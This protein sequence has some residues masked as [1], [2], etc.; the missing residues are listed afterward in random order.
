MRTL[1]DYIAYKRGRRD[2]DFIVA[3]SDRAIE[4]LCSLYDIAATP[5]ERK[6]MRG[7]FREIMTR[8]RRGR[9]APFC[10][11]LHLPL[12]IRLREH[13]MYVRCGLDP[14]DEPRRK[15]RSERAA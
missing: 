12:R 4:G 5:D 9:L 10:D 2:L 8:E 11:E 3:A 1:D 13:K 14:P 15:S 7:I 6:M